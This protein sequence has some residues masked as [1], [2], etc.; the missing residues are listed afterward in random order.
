MQH[1][2]QRTFANAMYTSNTE[3]KT[4]LR[5]AENNMSLKTFT[6]IASTLTETTTGNDP[7]KLPRD[8][9]N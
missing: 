4:I 8:E 7:D 9:V 6:K 5:L 1:K 2:S 3:L